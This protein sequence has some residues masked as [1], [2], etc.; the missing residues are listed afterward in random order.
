MPAHRRH[1]LERVG[2]G[3]RRGGPEAELFPHPD[4]GI[5]SV[6]TAAGRLPLDDQR[7]DAGVAVGDRLTGRFPEQFR[8]GGVWPEGVKAGPERLTLHVEEEIERA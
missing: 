1:L 7:L 4:P 6:G 2:R 5:G 8:K 3:D